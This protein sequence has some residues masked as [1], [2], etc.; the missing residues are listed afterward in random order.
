MKADKGGTL[1]ILP[2]SGKVLDF[3]HVSGAAAI[4]YKFTEYNESTRAVLAKKSGIFGNKGE[5][6]KVM[7][8]L[9]PLLF[10]HPIRPV[11]AY[12]TDPSFLL[13]KYLAWWYKEMANFC[14][15]R[16][17]LNSI[18]LAREQNE[19]VFPLGSHLVSFNTVNMFTRIS[20]QYSINL[21]VNHLHNQKLPEF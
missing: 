12:Y 3:L 10:G 8:P 7:C 13:S 20:V 5:S 18:N 14:P 21:T 2:C 6:L 9:T 4:C 11:V 15:K 16:S 19:Q 1:I 17:I